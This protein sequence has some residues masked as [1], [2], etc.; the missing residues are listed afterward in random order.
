MCHISW[1]T[2][3][4]TSNWLFSVLNF[5]LS[6]YQLISPNHRSTVTFGAMVCISCMPL[7]DQRE[8]T[9][10]ASVELYELFSIGDRK[11]L[12]KR[13]YQ[14][15]VE[16]VIPCSVCDVRDARQHLCIDQ[17]ARTLRSKM[18]QS[19]DRRRWFKPGCHNFHLHSFVLFRRDSY[20]VFHDF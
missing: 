7:R 8:Q 5:G 6:T 1:I 19:A 12:L 9:I 20:L 3:A 16:R 4:L 14:P 13:P 10:C 17:Q 2:L 15:W 18:I 11:M